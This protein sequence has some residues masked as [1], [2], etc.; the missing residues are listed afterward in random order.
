MEPNAHQIYIHACT[1]FLKENIKFDATSKH[2]DLLEWVKGKNCISL[3][4]VWNTMMN[5]Q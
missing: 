1:Y 2:I 3:Y 4:K 5:V